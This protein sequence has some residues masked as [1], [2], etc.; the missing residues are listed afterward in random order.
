[1]DQYVF[2]VE[3]KGRMCKKRLT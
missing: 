2:A 1:M 3:A